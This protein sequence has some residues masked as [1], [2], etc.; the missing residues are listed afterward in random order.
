LRLNTDI[1]ILQADNGNC[2]VVLEEA[3]CKAGLNTLLDFRVYEPLPE[4]LTG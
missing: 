3:K 2:M 4:N 1:R